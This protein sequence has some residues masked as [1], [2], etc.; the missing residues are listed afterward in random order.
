MKTP[1][2]IAMLLCSVLLLNACATKELLEK[3]T[4]YTHTQTVS[5]TLVADKVVAFGKP[6]QALPNVPNDAIVMVGDK[7]SYVL[8]QGGGQLATLLNRLDPTYLRVTQPLKFLSEK[9]D[10]QFEGE[11]ALRYSRLQAD[12]SKSDIQF[13][14]QNNVRECTS[15]S[16]KRMNVQSFCFDIDLVG[17]IYPPVN[18]RSSLKALSKSYPIEIY[19][20]VTE[21]QHRHDGKTAAKKVV[22]FPFAVAFDVIT[23]PFQAIY[24][25]FD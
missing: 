10:G 16:D 18:N 24:Q 23:L 3:E 25:I 4:S 21:E 2:N 13:F 12:V 7:Q 1:F 6:A 5:K 22:L 15:D 11:L 17:A 9:N 8:T 14:L 19:T 20:K